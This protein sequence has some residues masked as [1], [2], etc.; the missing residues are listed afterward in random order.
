MLNWALTFLLIAL[1]AAAFGF[2][3]IAASAAWIGQTLFGLFL[4]L[5]FIA[6]VTHL[7]RGRAPPL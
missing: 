2:G 1:I 4:I 3:G 5:F 6:L 7:V